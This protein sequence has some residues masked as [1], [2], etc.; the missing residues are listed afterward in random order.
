MSRWL[1]RLGRHDDLIEYRKSQ[2]ATAWMIAQ[3]YAELPNAITVS[4]LHCS[5]DT[6]SSGPS[7]H[8]PW[9]ALGRSKPRSKK[10][11]LIWTETVRGS[12]SRP[13]CMGPCLLGLYVLVAI[14]FE[15]SLSK[16]TGALV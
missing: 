12:A 13:L 7:R 1:K 11:T 4:V 9:L 2:V 8:P 5:I 6:L 3:A 15:A 10:P 16:R 14:P